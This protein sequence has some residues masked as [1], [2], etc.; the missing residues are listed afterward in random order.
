M[1]QKELMKVQ[2]QNPKTSTNSKE[3]SNNEDKRNV[4][5][6]VHGGRTAGKNSRKSKTKV[7]NTKMSAKGRDND[8]NW[9]FTDAGVAD[10]AAS[11]AFDQYLGV[12]FSMGLDVGSTTG[13][14]EVDTYVPTIM[15]ISVNPCPGDT[16][17]IQTGINMAALKTYTTLSSQ[18]AK[19][20]AYAPQDITT[21]ILSLGEVISVLEHIRRAFGVAFTYNQ[22]NR[23]MPTKLLD[24]MGFNSGDFLT[25]L[26][27]H[28]LEF[29]SWITAINK[30]P[31]LDNFAY[32]YKCADIYQ[33]VY[34][35]S[36]SAMAQIVFMRPYSTW[37]IS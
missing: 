4:K 1:N 22:R 23:S 36:E 2:T 30:I 28:R 27:Q 25:N 20:T 9:Y 6:G 34:S 26:A 5:T 7:Q 13:V 33:G 18:N 8:P 31:F 29:N 12:P 14:T 3:G 19:T 24:S 11:F 10:A 16:S 37:V 21:L 32:L 17:S 35:D 15:S